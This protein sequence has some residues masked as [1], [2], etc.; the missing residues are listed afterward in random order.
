MQDAPAPTAAALRVLAT[1]ATK[2]YSPLHARQRPLPR[3]VRLG[4]AGYRLTLPF[5]GVVSHHFSQ[6][7]RRIGKKKRKK[8]KVKA[9]WKD[10]SSRRVCLFKIDDGWIDSTR[11]NNTASFIFYMAQ[12]PCL[13][14]AT[15]AI[16]TQLSPCHAISCLC[17]YPWA[18]I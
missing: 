10:R 7:N 5:G 16:H 6:G 15:Y 2:P 8:A 1:A 11:S 4:L 14:R 9:G 12:L 17:V 3:H 13:F 18:C